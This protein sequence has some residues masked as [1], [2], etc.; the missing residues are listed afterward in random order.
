M[1]TRGKMD[2][3]SM[4]RTELESVLDHLQRN[5]EEM[6]EMIVFD[7]NFTSAHIGGH[8]VKKDEER[9]AKLKDEISRVQRLL[10]A[11]NGQ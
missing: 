5:L 8:R 6:E 7:Y 1:Q 2:Y 10:Y 4:S 9:L 11:K 3:N